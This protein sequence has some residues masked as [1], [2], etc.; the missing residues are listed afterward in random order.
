MSEIESLRDPRY[1]GS[2][3]CWPCTVVNI[4][5]LVL[6]VSWLRSRRRLLGAVLAT[7]GLAAIYV[8]GYFVP[9]TPRFAP[10]LVAASP[11]PD[12]W[13]H[14]DPLGELASDAGS[15]ADPIDLDGETVLREFLAADIVED[16][17]ET[18]FLAPDVESA[19][20]DRMADLASD[21]T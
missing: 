14:D 5:I 9:Y 13:F 21:P 18:L 7:A 12:E 15:L 11:L 1:T 16:D 3:R 4:A 17:G 20:H 19:W 8:R 10:A 6:L 2:E